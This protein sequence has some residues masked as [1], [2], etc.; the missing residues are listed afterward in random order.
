MSEQQLKDANLY[1]N[2]PACEL[3]FLTEEQHKR[4]HSKCRDLSFWTYKGKKRS[5][6]NRKNISLGVR[7]SMT[8]EIAY[9]HGNGTRQTRWWNNGVKCVRARECPEGFVAGRLKYN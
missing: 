4:L 2:R 7:A 9:K 8:K 6:Q 3:L 5:L 1:Y